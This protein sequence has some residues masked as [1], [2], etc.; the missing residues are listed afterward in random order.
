MANISHK[1]AVVVPTI[2]RYDDLRRM[3]A[4]LAAQTRLPDEV[5]IVDQD[6]TCQC[7]ASEFPQLPI[8][9]IA[10]PGS[11]SL[12]RNAGMEAARPDADLIGFFDDDIV[13]EPQCF[14]A[15]L[16]FWD[17]GP[18][19]LGGLGCNLMNGAPM[20]ARRLKGLPVVSRLGLYDTA[21]GAVLRSGFHTMTPGVDRDLYVRWLSSWA[22]VYPRRVLEE[23]RFDEWFESYSYLEDLD[24]SY[25]VSRKYRLA[26]VAGARF[27]HYPSRLGRPD[28]YLFGKKEV[29]NRLYFVSK[30]PELSRPLCCLALTIRA[31]MSL[32]LGLAYRDA[33][34]FQR[35]AGNAAGFLFTGGKQWTRMR[36]KITTA[37]LGSGSRS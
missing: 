36:E 32:F 8:R 9:V 22:V 1:L 10:L 24:L 20:F 17:S 28:P 30:H 2:G 7:F 4:S 35:V 3:L 26:M 33:T 37:A 11:A 27:Y 19:D 29:L 25:R 16:R 18:P 31:A 13:L 14:E 5:V 21:P 15:L 34:Y 6:G 23:F 12:K